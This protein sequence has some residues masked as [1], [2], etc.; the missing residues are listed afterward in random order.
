M[1]DITTKLKERYPF[2]IKHYPSGKVVQLKS[3][4][5]DF[6]DSH[7]SEWSADT[8]AYSV[9]PTVVAQKSVTRS[10][11]VSLDIPAFNLEEAKENMEHMQ[12]LAKFMYPSY[13][14]GRIWTS[15][16]LGV[17]FA[18]WINFS[19]GFQGKGA[20]TVDGFLPVYIED[21]TFNPIM[22]PGH[23]IEEGNTLGVNSTIYPKLIELS[24][25]MNAAA[26]NM[27]STSYNSD[28][29]GKDN[30][31]VNYPYFADL[32]ANSKVKTHTATE[33]TEELARELGGQLGDAAGDLVD[34]IGATY[35]NFANGLAAAAANGLAIVDT[36]VQHFAPGSKELSA[37]QKDN[38]ERQARKLAL[39][40][41]A[42][43][44]AAAKPSNTNSQKSAIQKILGW[45]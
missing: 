38:S 40:Q 5:K 43:A 19:K 28:A 37:A 36:G 14:N 16:F 25:T 45:D 20:G 29:K 24:L 30:P 31:W 6:S 39:I 1:A 7:K 9:G 42:R 32:G 33:E 21:F 12:Y 18:N 44:R 34:D 35:N 17:R 13:R 4:I 41:A 22:E 8:N 11:T 15:T 3:F 2:E 27:R 10:I 23:F 26:L